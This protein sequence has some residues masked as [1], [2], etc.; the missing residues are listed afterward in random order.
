MVHPLTDR[1][2]QILTLVSEGKSDWEIATILVMSPKT[3]NFHVENAKRKL[4]SPSRVHAVVVAIRDG[5]L[6]FPLP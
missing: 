3:T 4:G 2:V 6:P 5:V 1:E